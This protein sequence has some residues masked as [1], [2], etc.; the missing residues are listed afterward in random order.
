MHFERRMP[1]KMHKFF[2]FQRKKKIMCVPTLPTLFRPIT[3]NI[4]ISL[5]GLSGQQ[6]I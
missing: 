6:Q 3:R 1:F 5:F 2:F 4:L